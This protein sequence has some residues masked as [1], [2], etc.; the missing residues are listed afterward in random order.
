MTWKAY[1]AMSGAGLLATY[2]FSTPPPLS[3]PRSS[4]VTRGTEQP[5]ASTVDIQEEAVRLQSRVRGELEY[6]EPSRNLFRFGARPLTPRPSRTHE[7]AVAPSATPPVAG[8]APARQLP[9]LR[10][11]GI[12]TDTI[13][14]ARRR[15]A[16]L[17]TPAG[18]AEVKEGDTVLGEYRVVRIEED[19]VELA[20]AD[21]TPRRLTLR[22]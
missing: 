16:I 12:A 21:G 17:I 4:S 10:L 13:D 18:F 3:P 19:A 14:G 20:A 7:T 1:A 5:L 2:L 22:P 11:S 15:T 9:P 8:A 6:Q